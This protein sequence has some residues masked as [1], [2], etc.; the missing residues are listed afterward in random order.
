[1]G[2]RCSPALHLRPQ[3][4]VCGLFKEALLQ[5]NVLGPPLL[6]GCTAELPS[7]HSARQEQA[8]ATLPGNSQPGRLPRDSRASVSWNSSPSDPTQPLTQALGC[9]PRCST[10]SQ[11]PS[12][13]SSTRPSSPS[14]PARYAFINLNY[15]V[16]AW[17]FSSVNQHPVS[18][19]VA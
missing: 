10:L 18:L 9:K 16:R 7:R 5:I 19:P 6:H 17:T 14:I 1:M 11:R 8:A 13:K 2:P 4:P 12:R 15:E 3:Q